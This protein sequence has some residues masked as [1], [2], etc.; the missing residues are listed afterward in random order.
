LGYLFLMTTFLKP[1]LCY[2][3]VD[4]AFWFFASYLVMFVLIGLRTVLVLP[5][6]DSTN[7]AISVAAGFQTLV[8]LLV[9]FWVSS[10]LMA[11]NR[12]ARGSLFA[13]A[14]GC[15]LLG[16]I[17]FLGYTGDV[18]S[19]EGREAAFGT[20]PNLVASFLVSGLLVLL[21]LAYGQA[22][23]NRKARACF[24]FFSPMM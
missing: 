14:S 19:P 17:Q 11:D 23:M 24:W 13:F 6:P 20:N 12:I 1:R 5:E 4:K 3:R 18:V 16:A 9:L 21:G 15:I 7:I 22:N 2:R 10:N 8:Q